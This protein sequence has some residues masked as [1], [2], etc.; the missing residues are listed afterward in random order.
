[1]SYDRI[2]SIF[3][4]EH[5]PTY[6][7]KAQYKSAIWATTPEQ[8]EAAQRSK[9]EIEEKYGK[10]LATDI[11]PAK[12]WHDAEEYHQKYIEKQSSRWSVR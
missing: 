6:R 2:L 7:A 11:L 9:K 10:V 12:Q 4:K 5:N 1:M 8:L 3:W